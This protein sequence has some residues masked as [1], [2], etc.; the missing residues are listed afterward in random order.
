MVSKKY[1]CPTCKQEGKISSLYSDVNDKGEKI[2]CCEI[3]GY[4]QHC[5]CSPS[6][7]TIVIVPD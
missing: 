5:N 4:Q 1:F 6:D 3:H 7:F 2:L